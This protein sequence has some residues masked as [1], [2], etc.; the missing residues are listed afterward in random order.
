MTSTYTQRD[1]RAWSH[2]YTTGYA[3]GHVDGWGEGYTHGVDAGA[4]L[5]RGELENELDSAWSE[6][7]AHLRGVA[8]SPSHAQVIARR[9]APVEA[10]AVPTGNV[11]LVADWDRL[12]LAAAPAT[13]FL[14]PAGEVA[15]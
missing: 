3:V 9:N 7:K 15:A 10:K 2:G 1:V 11:R 13:R 12:W 6:M 8:S 5:G 4:P 14:R